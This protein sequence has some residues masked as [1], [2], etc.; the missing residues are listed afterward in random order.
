MVRILMAIAAMAASCVSLAAEPQK[1]AAIGVWQPPAGL[2]QI[3]IWPGVAP[4][5]TGNAQPPESVLT[6]RTPE[7]L[8]GA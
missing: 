4:D 5:M 7:A 3:P 2:K 1:T 8:D 6:A